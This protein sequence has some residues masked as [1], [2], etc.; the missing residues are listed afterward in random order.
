MI[1]EFESIWKDVKIHEI[2]PNKDADFEHAWR[3]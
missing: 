2:L 3:D 1:D